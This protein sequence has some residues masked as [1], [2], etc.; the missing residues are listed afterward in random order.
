MT[1]PSSKSQHAKAWVAEQVHAPPPLPGDSAKKPDLGRGRA[2][3]TLQ[4]AFLTAVYFGA[5]KLG[6]TMAFVAEQVTAVWPPTGIALAALLL[7]GY[8]LWP[9]I[10]LGAF[11]ANATANEPL[12]TAA[13][14]AL[15]N[16][17]EALLGAWL[18]R[19]LAQFDPALGRVKDVLSLVVLA[20][21]VS[22]R[23]S[24]TI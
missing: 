19:R 17:L 18:L 24:A 15:G 16:T 3:Y 4:V 6:L 11:L 14:I 8:R 10:A 2:F 23:V 5:A 12:G 1:S 21:G 7:F 20:A 9:G 13:G 22:T